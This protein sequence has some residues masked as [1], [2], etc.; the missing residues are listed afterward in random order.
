MIKAIVFD[1]NGVFVKAPEPRVIQRVRDA[2]GTGAWVA[3][4][5]YLLN[6]WDL[7]R[8]FID[9]F[10]FW[11]KVFVDLTKEEYFKFIVDEYDKPADKDEDVFYIAEKLAKKYDLYLISNSNFL[12]GKAYRKQKLYKLFKEFF[13]SHETREI[14]PFPDAYSNFFKETKLKPK[15]C[16]FIDDSTTNIL[17]AMIFGMKGIV[18]QDAEHLEQKLKKMKLL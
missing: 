7:E 3:K 1:F 12:Q 16:L 4:S 17:T 11:K 10:E 6:L 2:K 14:K 13:L 8:G 9:P 15:D 18:F 5:N